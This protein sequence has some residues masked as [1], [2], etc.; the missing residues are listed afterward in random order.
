LER[1]IEV[2][3]NLPP[4]SEPMMTPNSTG[5]GEVYQYYLEGPTKGSVSAA[6]MEQELIEQR[7]VEDWVIRPLIKGVPGVIDVN[8]QGGY[9]KQYQV[10]VEPAL[11]R[12]CALSLEE[13]FAAVK[14]NNANA[15]GNI[16]ET[17]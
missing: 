17:H 1:L 5:L 9:V 12:K 16:L 7:T 4:G 3:E 6:A 10:L 13:V 2:R 15:A 11:S 8:S 14:N